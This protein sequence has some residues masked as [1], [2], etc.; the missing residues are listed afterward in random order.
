[1]EVAGPER[2]EGRKNSGVYVAEGRS[3][4]PQAVQPIR[5]GIAPTTAPAQVFQI[6]LRFIQVYAPAYRAM[7]VNP[8][9]AVVGLTMV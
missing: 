7:F 2:K 9:I 5:G 8:R 1:M 3:F 6:D 4:P